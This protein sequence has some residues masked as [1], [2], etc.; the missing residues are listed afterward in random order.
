VYPVT[1]NIKTLFDNLLGEGKWFIK[2][3]GL[4]LVGETFAVGL[5]RNIA[6]TA[7]DPV[8]RTIS[9]RIL[10]D[11]SRHMAFSVLSLPDMIASLSGDDMHELEE[12]TGEALR[13]VLRGQFPREAF[14]RVGLTEQ[15]I[16]EIE[17]I[18]VETA[19]STDAIL[20]RQTFRREMYTQVVSNMKKVGLM[21][22]AIAENL[23]KLGIDPSVDGRAYSLEEQ[24]SA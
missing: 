12:F 8:L 24:L 4:Q 10:T 14:E 20:F 7:A 16:K 17:R 9:K 22:G 21:T 13:L 19:K 6:E 1:R 2:T 11:E 18:R 3:V 5:I 15:D 23:R